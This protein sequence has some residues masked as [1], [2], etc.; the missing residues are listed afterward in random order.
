MKRDNCPIAVVA[1]L[2]DV[3]EKAGMPQRSA[4]AASD[5]ALLREA[6]LHA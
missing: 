2:L 4:K 5:D 3:A 6:I 1:T